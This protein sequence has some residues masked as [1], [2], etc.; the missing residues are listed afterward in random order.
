M[1]PKRYPKAAPKRSVAAP[2]TIGRLKARIEV[3]KKDR[4]QWKHKAVGM[5]T[6][7]RAMANK[8]E[9]NKEVNKVFISV[10]RLWVGSKSACSQTKTTKL[11]RLPRLTKLPPKIV[12]CDDK[13]PTPSP[14]GAEDSS[15]AEGVGS[16]PTSAAS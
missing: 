4:D 11:D 6:F 16:E 3:L 9:Q 12:A 2:V 8:V 14:S 7:V 10:R 13:P 1:A 15:S 5:E